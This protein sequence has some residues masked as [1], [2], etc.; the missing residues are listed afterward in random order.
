MPLRS[1]L[2]ELSTAGGVGD[3]MVH[4]V[5]EIWYGHENKGAGFVQAWKA[6]ESRMESAYT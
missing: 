6:L 3:K 1:Y 2:S 5:P 4:A